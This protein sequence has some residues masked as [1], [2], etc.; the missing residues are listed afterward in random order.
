MIRN[1]LR[2]LPV[3]ISLGDPAGIGPEIVVRSLAARPHLNLRVFGDPSV[4]EAAAGR[5]GIAAPSPQ[6]IQSVSV[7]GVRELTPG[8]PS[9]V[10][11]RAQLAYLEAA[12]DAALSGEIAALC[13]APIS[14]EWIGRAGF[15]FPGHTE[16]LAARAGITEFA[17]MLAGP[18][19]RVVLAT[20]HVALREVPARL[21]V[22]EIVRATVLVSRALVDS[23]GSGRARVAVAGLNPHAGESGRFGDEEQ[24]L[25]TPAILRARAILENEAV[26]CVISGPL[27]PDAV[28]RQAA[29]GEFDAV[30]AQYHDQGLIPLKLLHFEDAVNITLGLPFPR[31]SPDHGTAYGIAGTGR[32]SSASF[33]AAL[34]LA[35]EL[36]ERRRS[37]R[38]RLVPGT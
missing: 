37:P 7:A 6:R 27:P 32:A 4:L 16:Y 17:M 25:I 24:R 3:G 14:K 1:A 34:D 22:E 30:V 35:A 21:T 18:R 33:L 28:F 5:M 11:A 23:F 19:L 8:A 38:G 10:S 26:P 9:L 13:T 20:R 31:T 29:L 15:A 2:S 12:T 36:A